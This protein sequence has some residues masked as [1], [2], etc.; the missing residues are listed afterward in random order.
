[1]ASNI[2]YRWGSYSQGFCINARH[3][4]LYLFVLSGLVVVVP[5]GS[6]SSD[7]RKV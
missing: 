2:I 4:L 6:F 3:D 7:L 1:M 5:I